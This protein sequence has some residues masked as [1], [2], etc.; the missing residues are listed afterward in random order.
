MAGRSNRVNVE[1]TWFAAPADQPIRCSILL[2]ALE[3]QWGTR[4]YKNIILYFSSSTVMPVWSRRAT[5]E[6]EFAHIQN[7]SG[8]VTDFRQYCKPY[9]VLKP[10]RDP[11]TIIVFHWSWFTPTQCL[12][13]I[14]HS[15]HLTFLVPGNYF[16][17]FRL[18]LYPLV[19][20]QV[21]VIYHIENRWSSHSIRIWA[22]CGVAPSC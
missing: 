12:V 21:K 10:L 2:L 1:T 4:I 22:V 5:G 7:T 20:S 18:Y 9:I 6:R 16:D 3:K 19:S 17:D 8:V 14:V 11:H 13:S 15:L